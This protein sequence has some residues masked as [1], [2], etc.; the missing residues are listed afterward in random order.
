MGLVAD[1]AAL[2]VAGVGFGR[3]AFTVT[4]AAVSGDA[5]GGEAADVRGA[6]EVG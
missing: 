1:G 4:V 3:F 5:F 2:G 6:G